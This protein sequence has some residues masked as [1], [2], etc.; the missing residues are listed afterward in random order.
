MEVNTLEVQIPPPPATGLE[1]INHAGV[2]A[3]V[4]PDTGL[5]DLH[6]EARSRLCQ[7]S[8]GNHH[9]HIL[10]ITWKDRALSL[11]SN[12]FHLLQ[13]R[14]RLGPPPN[15]PSPDLAVLR[16]VPVRDANLA[17]GPA[18]GRAARRTVESARLAWPAGRPAWAN[19]V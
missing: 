3:R 6:I 12:N 5:E 19:A 4:F 1:D 18:S 11:V 16:H 17:A 13:G 15:T 8:R 14:A 7:Q 10:N 2:R 9:G